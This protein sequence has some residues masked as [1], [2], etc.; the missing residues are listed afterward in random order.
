[1]SEAAERPGIFTLSRSFDAPLEMVWAAFT[2]DEHLPHWW[3]PPG[4]EWL[5]HTLDFRPGGSFHYGMRSPAGEMWGLFLYEY[6]D[7][8]NEMRFLN[9]FSNEAGEIVR[10]PFSDQY[11][12][13]VM[14]EYRF[15]EQDGKTVMEMVAW[16]HEASDEEIAFYTGMHTPMRGG[17]GG[18]LDKL[19]DYLAGL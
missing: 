16:P 17:F 12:L 13:Y 3:G 18:T 9:G 14:N 19:A 2:E 8:P 6:I 1:M 7:A 5:G 15:L 4:C 11:P 10:A